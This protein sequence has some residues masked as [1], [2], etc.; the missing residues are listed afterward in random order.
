MVQDKTVIDID[1]CSEVAYV[2]AFS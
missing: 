1:Y 2:L